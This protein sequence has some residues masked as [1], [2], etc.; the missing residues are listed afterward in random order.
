M[1]KAQR[2]ISRVRLVSMVRSGEHRLVSMLREVIDLSLDVESKTKPMLFRSNDAQLNE[3]VKL[4]TVKTIVLLREPKGQAIAEARRA[5]RVKVGHFPDEDAQFREIW[6]ARHAIHYRAFIEKWGKASTANVQIDHQLL[7]ADPVQALGKAI[8]AFGRRVS[9]QRIKDVAAAG[10]ETASV[11]ASTRF[12]PWE[13]DAYA[14]AVADIDADNRIAQ[15]ARLIEDSIR[16]IAVNS[17]LVDSIDNR[18]LKKLL[19]A[20]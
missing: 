14:E 17:A 12:T 6:L 7:T 11:E 1:A 4:S 3:P 9:S 13:I 18:Q 5:R 20:A 10:A 15:I 19:L 16:G 8:G 2:S